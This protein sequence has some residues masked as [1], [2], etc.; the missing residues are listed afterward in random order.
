M[1]PEEGHEGDTQGL[2]HVIVTLARIAL[3]TVPNLYL[4]QK[5]ANGFVART[6]HNITTQPN[7]PS[8]RGQLGLSNVV[9]AVYN[10]RRRFSTKSWYLKTRTLL[11]LTHTQKEFKIRNLL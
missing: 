4:F 6:N 11:T 2:T 1:T 3:V 5:E 8:S 7:S 10:S 9:T